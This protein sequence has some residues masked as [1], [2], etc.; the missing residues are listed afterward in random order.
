MGVGGLVQLIHRIGRDRGQGLLR[1]ARL[2]Q[3][4]LKSRRH[5]RRMNHPKFSTNSLIYK[6][7]R[8]DTHVRTPPP[9]MRAISYDPRLFGARCHGIS[10]FE[11]FG[12]NNEHCGVIRGQILSSIN[13]RHGSVTVRERRSKEIKHGPVGTG[14]APRGSPHSI[15][16]HVAHTLRSED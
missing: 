6:P 12:S 11:P 16:F 3:W 5:S 1:A 14:Q 13:F 10:G 4:A 2:Q 9:R 8:L 7:S 15:L